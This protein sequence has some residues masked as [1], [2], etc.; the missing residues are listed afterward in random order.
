MTTSITEPKLH[1]H[2]AYAHYGTSLFWEA[3]LPER[4]MVIGDVAFTNFM[5][6]FLVFLG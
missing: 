3:R 5:V 2:A 4:A 1:P 6:F